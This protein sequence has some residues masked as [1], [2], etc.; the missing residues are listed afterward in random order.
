MIGACST[1]MSPRSAAAQDLGTE[2]RYVTRHRHR[3][4]FP[5][6]L[7]INPRRKIADAAQTAFD[8]L[9]TWSESVEQVIAIGQQV[10]P[11]VRRNS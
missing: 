6:A 2:G 4:R 5:G 11:A 8:K 7:R 3:Q 9:V 1:V 10:F